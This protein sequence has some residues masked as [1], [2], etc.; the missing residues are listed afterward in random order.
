MTKAD[1][2]IFI[3]GVE[4]GTFL[5]LRSRALHN[6]PNVAAHHAA[7][8]LRNL[9]GVIAEARAAGFSSAAITKAMAAGRKEAREYGY[10]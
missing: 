4:A 10:C 6:M 9:A 1:R 8:D 2:A 7:Q 5:A 3:T